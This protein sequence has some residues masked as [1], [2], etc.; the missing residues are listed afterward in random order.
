MKVKIPKNWTP[1]QAE[2]IA[3]FIADLE[4][5][6]RRKYQV[7]ILDHQLTKLKREEH[8]AYSNNFNVEDF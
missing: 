5:A 6:I 8:R 1:E 7:K 2:A 4:F 3:D